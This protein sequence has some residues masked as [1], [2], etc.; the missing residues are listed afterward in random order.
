MKFL[1]FVYVYASG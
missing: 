1:D